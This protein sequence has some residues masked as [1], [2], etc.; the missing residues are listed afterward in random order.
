MIKIKKITSELP[1]NVYELNQED[2]IK[3]YTG[4]MKIR[5]FNVKRMFIN[6]PL[7]YIMPVVYLVSCP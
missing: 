6:L 4:S 7:H 5:T 2:Y 1:V 3:I